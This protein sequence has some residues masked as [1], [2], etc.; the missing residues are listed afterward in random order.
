MSEHWI[1][2]GI[3]LS[4]G[5]SIGILWNSLKLSL[6]VPTWLQ[7]L[8]ASWLPLSA[9]VRQRQ[10][11]FPHEPLSFYVRGEALPEKLD[12]SLCW[13]PSSCKEGWERQFLPGRNGLAGKTWNSHVS[14]PRARPQEHWGV[15]RKEVKMGSRAGSLLSSVFS[16]NLGSAEGW[17]M[18]E[19][20]PAE[21][22]K[23]ILAS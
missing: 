15:A 14:F 7:W 23:D 1:V 2:Y 4:I 22:E 17:G 8:Q 19:G 13:S 16:C 12:F 20:L 5:Y 9:R 6:M 3:E 21:A 10:S 11:P 18:L